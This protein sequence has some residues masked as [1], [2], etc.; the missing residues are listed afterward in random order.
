MLQDTTAIR[1]RPLLT[2]LFTLLDAHRPA[3]RQARPFQRLVA[4]VVG[5]LCAFGR[6]TITQ[7]LVALGLTAHDW[8]AFYRL[9]GVPRLD[10]D[11]LTRCFLGEWLTSV[12]PDGPL[13][14]V[15]DAVQIPR[16]SGRMPGTSWLKAPRTPAFRPGIHRAQ[17]F[18][19][20]AG[21]LPRAETGYSR[22]VPLR[23]M[24][25]FPPKARPAAGVAPQ[26]E[27]AAGL[28]ALSWL[29]SELDLAGRTEQRV[30]AIADGQYSG[31]ACWRTLPER[32]DLMARCPR[33]RAL[34]ALPTPPA[35]RGRP[36]LYGAR[37]PRP[38]AWLTERAGWQQT[39]IVARG[40]SIPLTY[41][42]EGPALVRGA[43]ERPLFLLV[44]R[45][46]AAGAGHRERPPTFWLVSAVPDGAGGWTLPWPV[47]ELLAWAWQR[48]EIEVTHRELKAEFGLG[49]TQCW[50]PVSAVLAVQCVAWAYAVLVLAG[51]RVWGLAPGPVPPPGRWWTG[52]RRWSLGRLWQGLRQELWQE[53]E[54]RPLWSRTPD[55]WGE[56][57]DW[58]AARTNATLGSRRG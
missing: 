23:F 1:P 54:F 13:V 25:A 18:E 17:R 16:A 47:A 48:W 21:L 29:R 12:P 8:S 2:E 24:P 36:R 49:E 22:A 5:H 40:R 39:T 26:T 28:A 50:G 33:N 32:V 7:A 34:Y 38:D 9:F 52:A 15:M 41:R 51:Y 46:V 4:L 53:A 31:Q 57:I 58:L 44:V 20:L 3:C 27:G 10:Y 6:Q 45:G 37:A 19:H 55:R 43:P 42:V 56:M 30:L 35:G 11:Q 14:V